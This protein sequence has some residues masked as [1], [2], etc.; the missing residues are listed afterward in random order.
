[1]CRAKIK[2]LHQLLIAVY[3]YIMY[4]I[5]CVLYLG[6]LGYLGYLGLNELFGSPVNVVRRWMNVVRFNNKVGFLSIIT[7][8]NQKRRIV[9]ESLSGSMAFNLNI[10]GV[11]HLCFIYL[12]YFS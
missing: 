1:M 2:I 8:T 10:S 4:V 9:N 12:W 11:C 3:S 5:Y 7:N 6:H